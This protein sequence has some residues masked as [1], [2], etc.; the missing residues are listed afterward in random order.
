MTNQTLQ[1]YFKFD[2]SDLEANRRGQF[3]EKQK[4]RLSALNKKERVLRW[5]LGII[6]I[7]IT[8][9]DVVVAPTY[10]HDSTFPTMTFPIGLLA[11]VIGILVLRTTKNAD[12]KYRLKKIQGK[13]AY[14]RYKPRT[15]KGK[16][17]NNLIIHFDNS[18]FDVAEDT[19][20]ILKEGADYVVYTYALQGYT[21]IISAELISESQ[22]PTSAVSSA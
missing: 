8:V 6:L 10:W 9:V 13:V 21:N 11:G 4:A 17:Y 16:Q 22:V 7:G 5:V 14:T 20:T 18:R 3:S 2:D 1:S 15:V 12:R 19:P